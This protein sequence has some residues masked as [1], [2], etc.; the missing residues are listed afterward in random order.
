MRYEFDPELSPAIDLLPTFDLQ[1][2]AADRLALDALAALA[3]RELDRS[4]VHISDHRIP[5]E[6]GLQVPVRVYRPENL[7]A[8][9]AGLMHIHGGGFAAVPSAVGT[10]ISALHLSAVRRMC[11]RRPRLPAR[12]TWPVCCQPASR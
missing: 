5:G 1:D 7:V 2:C 10:T 12:R 8:A 3:N 11:R 6:E 9:V 4:G